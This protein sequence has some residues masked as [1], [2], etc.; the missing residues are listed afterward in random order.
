[1]RATLEN[2][3]TEIGGGG[4]S[5][6]SDGGGGGVSR[7]GFIHFESSLPFVVKVSILV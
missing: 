2:F 6:T 1:M 5:G 4:T 7:V 3:G